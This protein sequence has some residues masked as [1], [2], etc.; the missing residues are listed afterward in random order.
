MC[1]IAGIIAKKYLGNEERAIIQMTKLVAH[2][3]P[4]GEG[5]YQAGNV[6]LGQRRLAILDL[7]NDAAQPMHYDN[8]NYSITFNGEI[9]NYI[10]LKKRLQG[11]GYQFHTQSDTEVILAAYKEWGQQCVTHFNGMWSFAIYDRTKN[12]LF[13]SRDRFGVK[14]FYYT[15]SATT[16]AFGSEIRQLL[17][18]S[19]PPKANVGLMFDFIL[20]GITDHTDETF[21]RNI[22]KLSPGCNLIYDLGNH[23]FEIRRYYNIIRDNSF[24]NISIGDA[25]ELFS[26]R[27]IDSV[28]LRLRADVKVGT[29]LSGG[30]DS[31]SIAVLASQEYM[32]KTREQF[33]AIT[34][35]STDPTNDETL[36]ARSIVEHS[37]LSWSITKPSYED[38]VN[39]IIPVLSTQ[40]EPFASPSVIMQY[41]VMQKARS[42][43]VPVLLDGQA[44]D[45]TLLGYDRYFG[46]YLASIWREKGIGS[47]VKDMQNMINNNKN[48]NCLMAVAYTG[49]SYS[50]RLR[51]LLYCWRHRYLNTT[52]SIAEYQYNMANTCF[53]I[54]EHQILEIK[55]TNLPKLLRYEDKN[56]MAHSVETRLPFLD[57]RLVELSLSLP[58]HYKIRDGWT[59]WILREAMSGK[60]PDNI[61]WRK[62]KL[63]FESPERI[64]LSRYLPEM[65]REIARSSFINNFCKME[66]LMD[67]F[68][69]MDLRSQWRL[70]VLS[71]WEREFGVIL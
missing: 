55:S 10:E 17:Y 35:S 52:P 66:K 62:N 43:G 68:P 13:A 63:G 36:Y 38:F 48:I 46:P 65:Q 16:F 18:L 23:H 12:L 27:L 69:R 1:G 4:D 49:A 14:P 45:E 37:Q 44:G 47:T 5:I 19:A 8:R 28:S 29:C 57:Y 26:A 50:A 34:A 60:M 15:D 59:K 22:I 51:H 33:C 3:G 32:R 31:S 39:S 2:R 70:Y 42:L 53:D 21:F 9:Y 11:K 6:F 54:F 7:S 64:W 71:L 61:V 56:S 67:I 25:V 20:T 30:L 58:L 40:E 24:Q 41:Y